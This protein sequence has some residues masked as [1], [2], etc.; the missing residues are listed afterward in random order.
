MCPLFHY[1]RFSLVPCILIFSDTIFRLRIAGN[2][3]TE[4]KGP[5]VFP[6]R[7]FLDMVTKNRYK[8]IPDRFDWD[9]TWN[10]YVKGPWMEHRMDHRFARSWCFKHYNRNLHLILRQRKTDKLLL[11]T[12]H[13]RYR[14]SD[15]LTKFSQPRNLS[16][17]TLSRYL[18]HNSRATC[19][20]YRSIDYGYARVHEKLATRT[21]LIFKERRDSKKC[22]TQRRGSRLN[23]YDPASALKMLEHAIAAAIGRARSMPLLSRG[24]MKGL[25]TLRRLLPPLAKNLGGN[26]RREFQAPAWSLIRDHKINFYDIT[27]NRSLAGSRLNTASICIVCN[28]RHRGNVASRCCLSALTGVDLRERYSVAFPLASDSSS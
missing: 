20:D 24:L 23:N 13:P 27:Q 16:P 9:L 6:G 22:H 3:S 15:S 4:E 5:R 25:A 11:L 10:A 7:V 21:K 26:F 12:L 2:S 17:I 18:V 28:R 1:E 19:H 14:L 8:K